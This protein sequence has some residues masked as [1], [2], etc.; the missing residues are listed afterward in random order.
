MITYG[1]ILFITFIL[2]TILPKQYT[3]ILDLYLKERF[4]R[5]KQG[6]AYSELKEINAG[7]PQGSVLGPVL[8]TLYTCDLPQIDNSTV[9]TFADDTAILAVGNSNEEA[10]EKLQTAIDQ[11][12]KWTKKWRIHL[13]ETKSVHTNF[14]Y[15]RIEYIPVNINK[16][17][18]PYANTAKYLGMTLDT[19]LRWKAHVKKKREELGIRYKKMYWLLGR[20]SK[21]SLHNKLLLYNQV[22][23]PVWTYSIQLWGCTSHSNRDII[24]RFQNEVLRSIADAPWF[25]RNSDLHRDLKVDVVVNEI[26]RFAQKHEGRLHQHENVEALQLLDNSDVVRRL[27]RKKPYDLV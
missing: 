22:L 8:Y 10:T 1:I 6:D 7:L 12:Q 11:I 18:V 5:I 23:K 15:K 17:K 9:A 4:F 16:Q 2:F 26:K 13:N 24:Q 25:V 19:K 27:Q 14:T 20:K 3:E 21:L